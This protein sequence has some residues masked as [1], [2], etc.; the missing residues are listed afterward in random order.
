MLDN[1][2]LDQIKDSFIEFVRLIPS[3]GALIACMD[4]P[5]VAEIAALVTGPVISYGTGE[6]CRWQLRNLAVSGLTSTFAAYKDG[7]LVI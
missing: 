7:T 3:D 5:V 6:N 2:D 4:D 1:M